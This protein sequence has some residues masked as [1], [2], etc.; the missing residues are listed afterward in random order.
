MISP[1]IINYIIYHIRLFCFICIWKNQDVLLLGVVNTLCYL[2]E[3]T[4]HDWG[5]LLLSTTLPRGCLEWSCSKVEQINQQQRQS[6][7]ASLKGFSATET[8]NKSVKKPGNMV[9]RMKRWMQN[10]HNSLLLR[11]IGKVCHPSNRVQVIIVTS[12][13]TEIQIFEGSHLFCLNLMI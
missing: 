9:A 3:H 10:L 8:L 5:P 1:L 6:Y 11:D 12:Y 2:R 13:G 7:D 4:P